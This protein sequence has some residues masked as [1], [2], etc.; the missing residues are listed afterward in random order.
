[1]VKWVRLGES[2]TVSI[3]VPAW[4]KREKIMEGFERL[5]EEKSAAVGVKALRPRLDVE[6]LSETIEITDKGVLGLREV[7]KKRLQSSDNSW[8]KK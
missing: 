8:C 1:L 3:R 7:E 4:V 2:E 6:K 5:L